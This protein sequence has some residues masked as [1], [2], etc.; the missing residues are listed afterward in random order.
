MLDN[1]KAYLLVG[2]GSAMGGMARFWLTQ[3]IDGW[4]AKALPWG[5]I[6]VNI[7]GSFLI[8]ALGAMAAPQ[9]ELDSSHQRLVQHFLMV[10]I[11]GGYTTFSSF[12]LQTLHLAQKGEWL[13]AGANVVVSLV[14]CL[15][16]VWLGCLAGQVLKG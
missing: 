1:I 4:L 7:S 11:C 14:L 6:V 2:L 9:A 8:G 3:M 10:G 16:A 13:Q 12:S 15:M 5:T